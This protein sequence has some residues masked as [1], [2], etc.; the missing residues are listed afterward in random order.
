MRI[1][2]FDGFTFSDLFG[3]TADLDVDTEYGWQIAQTIVSRAGESPIFGTAN[4]TPRTIDVSFVYNGSR[5]DY[6]QLFDELLGR[7]R[8]EDQSDRRK[9]YATRPDGTLVWRYARISVPYETPDVNSAV[10]RFVSADPR[11]FEL[12]A[13]TV[14]PWDSTWTRPAAIYPGINR[15]AI[16][17]P[18]GGTASVH[19]TIT[20]EAGGFSAGT[21]GWTFRKKQTIT[22]NLTRTISN[23]V[24]LFDLGD[25]AAL[26]S[27]GKALASGN[28]F[29]VVGPTGEEIPRNLV[30]WNTA[31]SWV[32]VYIAALEPGESQDYYFVYGNSA[33]GAPDTLQYPYLPAYRIDWTSGTSSSS[34]DAARLWI[35]IGTG[36]SGVNYNGKWN[37]CALYFV[38]GAN[39]GVGKRITSSDFDETNPGRVT[40]D[41]AFTNALSTADDWV[42]VSSRNPS[43]VAY[44]VYNTII[45]ER[46][47]EAARGRWYLSSGE[48]PPAL[49]DYTV[50]GS[51]Q[52]YLYKD[53]RDKKGQPRYSRVTFSSDT[54]SYAILNAQRTW[55]NGPFVAEEGAADGVSFSSPFPITD[56]DSNLTYFNNLGMAKAFI[57]MRSSGGN[58]WQEVHSRSDA[59]GT[60]YIPTLTAIPA[61]AT[62]IYHGLIPFEGDEITQDWRRDSGSSTAVGSTTTLVDS[63][64]AWKTNQW[65]GATLKMTGGRR[66]G[67]Q[68][69]ITSNTATVITIGTTLGTSTKSDQPYEIINPPTS[70][71]VVDTSSGS[72]GSMTVLTLD[73]SGLS[74]AALSAEDSCIDVSA[75]FWIGGG[76]ASS[77]TDAG[78][79]RAKIEVGKDADYWLMLENSSGDYIELD[80]GRRSSSQKT[81][82]GVVLE[83][84]VDP[85]VRWRYVD[86]D[87]TETASQN[88][89]LIPPGSGVLVNPGAETNVSNWTKTNSGT[90]T[91][92]IARDTVYWVKGVASFKLNISAST[93][94]AFA[95][96]VGDDRIPIT[97][98]DLAQFA[99]YV[100]TENATIKPLLGI[101]FYS[102]A[103]S[104][105]STDLQGTSPTYTTGRWYA[106][107]H[108]AVAPAASAFWAPVIR[109]NIASGSP[110]G[111]VFFD[112]VQAASPIIFLQTDHN[113]GKVTVTYTEA[114]VM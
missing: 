43:G 95:E 63:K 94:P 23:V 76:E 100:L 93:G 10:V 29:R 84:Y 41:S 67:Q 91:S 86:E 103:L 28:D 102:A 83:R 42:I 52:P 89:M 81:S 55:E 32:Y 46:G 45:A 108:A 74:I 111:A 96:M 6:W 38:N 11:W 20:I 114:Y 8:P 98:G 59:T 64:K 44:W 68:F 7:L 60:N 25:T 58:D 12:T 37:D 65:A 87:G 31:L 33:A 30:N 66:S 78:H 24:L 110:T 17:V 36:A 2:G 22:N 85:R 16:A 70:A 53:G 18:N 57:G 105:I 80:S 35:N 4:A 50:P 61:N 48:S 13:T 49:V 9:L 82:A 104:T 5:I 34:V 107:G 3:D 92:T 47:S 71:H 72:T 113:I 77:A 99:A 54:D 75:R 51:W 15:A 62:Q 21:G 79:R 40:V 14:Q 97:P 101:R 88:G 19:P 90:I 112:D 27:G 69:S 73:V 1:T 39:A 109:A 56:Y 26:V 106:E